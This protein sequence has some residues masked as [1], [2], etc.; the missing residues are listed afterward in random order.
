MKVPAPYLTFFHIILVG[1]LWL[2]I[3]TWSGCQSGLQHGLSWSEWEWCLAE[4]EKLLSQS[5]LSGLPAHLAREKT[6]PFVRVSF[7]V[8]FVC[9]FC[10]VSIGT[11]RLLASSSSKSKNLR[12][13]KNPDLCCS[14]EPETHSWSSFFPPP[15]T[16]LLY[17]MSRDFNC[18]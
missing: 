10:S 2:F 4:V 13:K 18:I 12:H 9:L 5:A 7:V 16:F 3:T 1:R 17:I 6:P 15:F 11:S 8:V 14:L